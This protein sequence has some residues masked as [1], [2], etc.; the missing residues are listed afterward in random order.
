MAVKE[1]LIKQAKKDGVGL[2]P[3]GRRTANCSSLRKN[4]KAGK[5]AA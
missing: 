2:K 1:E 4:I 3:R 5:D